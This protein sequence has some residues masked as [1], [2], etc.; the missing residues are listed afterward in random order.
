MIHSIDRSTHLYFWY[1]PPSSRLLFPH[2]PSR[3]S[4]QAEIQTTAASGS[5]Q[6][7]GAKPLA[8]TLAALVAV[9]PVWL[10][11]RGIVHAAA[12]LLG[13]VVSLL[14]VRRV[15]ALLLWRTVSAVALRLLV[16]LLRVGLQLVL[17]ALGGRA[18]IFR[19]EARGRGRGGWRVG[20]GVLMGRWRV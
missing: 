15:I 4:E 17:I 9:I 11:L 13:A 3:V 5:A 18:V 8:G 16:A 20:A 19:T 1:D 7:A 10:L 14:L 6:Q 2:S 12:L